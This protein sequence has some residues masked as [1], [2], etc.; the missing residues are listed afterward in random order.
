MRFANS[1]G[2]A[3]MGLLVASLSSPAFA[4]DNGPR[5]QP[6]P[7]ERARIA[8]AQRPRIASVQSASLNAAELV[9]AP[10]GLSPYLC[11]PSGFGRTARCYLRSAAR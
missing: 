11:T 2:L 10:S 1:L 8:S 9:P 3:A 5:A 4:Q 6:N 7:K